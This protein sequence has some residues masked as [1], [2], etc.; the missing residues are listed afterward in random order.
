MGIEYLDN[1]KC[2]LVVY[3]GSDAYG[4]PRRFKKTVKYTSPRNAEKQYRQFE[5]EVEAGLKKAARISLSEMMDSYIASRKRKGLRST[6][7]NQYEITKNRI[8]DTLGDPYADKVSR[9][10]IDDWIGKLDHDDFASK[11]IKNTVHFLSACYERSIDMEIV[12]KNPCHR[13]DIPDKPKKEIVTLSATEVVPF[14]N[15]LQEYRDEDLDFVVGIELMLFCGLRRS[16]VHGLKERD[17]DMFNKTVHVNDARHTIH[18]RMIEEGTKTARSNRVLSLPE[19]VFKDIM[20]LISIHEENRLTD[21]NLPISEYLILNSIGEPAHPNMMYDKLKKMTS[22]KNLPDVTLHGLRHTY[23][24]MLKWR[25][26]DLVEISGQLGHS[27]QST[28]L[29]IYTHLFQDA[30]VASKGI[31]ADLDEFISSSK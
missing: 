2:R 19:F 24:S 28:T 23:A 25:G 5:N 21:P 22:E 29:N 4:K 14:Y 12:T 6:T 30:S 8:L 18:G 13:A 31:A 26:R 11:T 1:K 27:Q 20:E 16:E 17:V 9:K 15:A 10:M 3:A 7:L